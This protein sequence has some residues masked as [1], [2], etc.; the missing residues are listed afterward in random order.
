MEAFQSLGYQ[1]PTTKDQIAV[2]EAF[3]SGRDVFMSLP[4][5]SGKS[6]CY[7]CLPVVFDKLSLQ[8]WVR[9]H[10]Q[11]I[12]VV[13]ASLSALLHRP[14]NSFQSRA[15]LSVTETSVTKEAVRYTACFDMVWQVLLK[16]PVYQKQLVALAIA[17]MC[18]VF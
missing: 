2:T 17:T 18:L 14:V 11:A 16:T 4:T 15:A 10:H 5:G 12:V 1:Y 8:G 7:G 9:G 6:V 3:I 13:V